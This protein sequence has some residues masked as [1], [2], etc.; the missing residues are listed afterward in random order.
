MGKYKYTA[1]QDEWLK[2]NAKHFIWSDLSEE[3]YK[4]FGIVKKF[5]TLKSHCNNTLKCSP[6]LNGY[7]KGR[8]IYN[9]RPL[10]S[11]Y[12]TP[13]GYTYVKISDKPITRNTKGRSSVN[14]KA[15]HIIEWEK[16][17]KKQLPEGFTVSFLDGDKTNFDIDNLI[18]LPVSVEAKLGNFK[19]KKL[20]VQANKIYGLMQYENEVINKISKC[21]RKESQ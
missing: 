15:K 11:E 5:R 12:V 4:K 20:P 2:E 19:R 3:F 10:G 9:T 18:A 14:W 7:E 13:N 17:N 1:E 8:V 6:H 21:E 16:Y